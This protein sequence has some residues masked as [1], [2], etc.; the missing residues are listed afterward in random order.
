M[1]GRLA[2]DRAT[3]GRLRRAAALLAA[4]L[5][6]ACAPRFAAPIADPTEIMAARQAVAEAGRLTVT[7]R[8]PEEAA[9]LLA[10]VGA[11]V[12]T[13]AE[14][15]CAAHLR[16]GCGLAVVLDPDPAVR[17]ALDG[18]QVRVSLGM[19]RLLA[20]E[21]EMAAVVGHEYGHHI[22]EHLSHRRL[23]GAATGTA[24]GTI[25]SAV[26]PFG[27]VAGFLLG[28]G[29][30][31]LGAAGARQAFSQAEEREAD[32]LAAYLVARAGYDLDRAGAVWVRLTRDPGETS[33]WLSTHPGGPERLAAWRRAAAEVR[34]SPTMAPRLAGGS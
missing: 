15:L 13:A 4:G 5:L 17:A 27:G 14:P 18:A 3:S 9:V 26:V 7:A 21:D 8:S 32:Y 24:A 30:A 34:A 23:R 16:A 29:A 2:G 28:Q 33:G 10:V 25:L 1:E 11:R 31:E 20:N 19:M 6:G 22:A 12:G